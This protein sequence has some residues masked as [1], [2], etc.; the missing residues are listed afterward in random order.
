MAYPSLR[1]VSR[2]SF[3]VLVSLSIALAFVSCPTSTSPTPPGPG[4][5]DTTFLATG[6]G[7]TGAVNSI[8]VQSD[9]KVL[10]G[11]LFTSYNGTSRGYVA[12]LNTDGSLDTGFLATG[13]GANNGVYS[14]AVQPSDGKI[15]IGGL[16]TSYNGTS[17]G[18]VARLNTDGS[19]DTGFLATGAGAGSVT[20]PYRVDSIAV[21]SDGKILIGGLF[22][23]Y[24]G[25]S[26]GYVARLNTDGS[27]DTGSLA[28]G[29]GANSEVWSIAVQ[30]DGKV[31]IG[32]NF[33]TYNGTGRGYVARLNTDGSLDT[34]FLATGAGANGLVYS[35]AVQPGDG[36][37]L[38][39][40][41]FTTYNGTS[42]GFVARLLN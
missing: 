7:A 2:L 28:T 3:L 20:S 33:T 11:G 15:L 41:G 29:A 21:Q 13:A 9:G 17:R 19:L 4:D 23:S 6:A 32:G 22:T 10:I 24:N 5:L 38:I 42:R 14:V 36:K 8:A 16:F 12:R 35:V 34:G 31:L 37:I 40:G 27:L 26:R 25:T 30:S 18:C 39:G 1:F